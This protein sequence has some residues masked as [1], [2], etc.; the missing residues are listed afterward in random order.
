V[1][2]QLLP[3]VWA[4]VLTDKQREVGDDAHT[5]AYIHSRLDT[6]KRSDAVH[7]ERRAQR[8]VIIAS[9]FIGYNSGRFFAVPSADHYPT[10]FTT[11]CRHRTRPM[12]SCTH[13]A[14]TTIATGWWRRHRCA[15]GAHRRVVGTVLHI[16]TLVRM[17]RV[18]CRVAD[19]R[20]P[21]G[22]VDER[23]SGVRASRLSTASRGD[24]RIMHESC[25]TTIGCCGIV[26]RLEC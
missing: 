24:T 22:G 20:W 8:A 21:S 17:G 7:S 6:V 19:P 11:F 13:T 3:I 26:G 5:C 23:R 14:R 1:C 4:Q 18:A 16:R 25:A 2:V 12:A 15:V 10:E 9:Q